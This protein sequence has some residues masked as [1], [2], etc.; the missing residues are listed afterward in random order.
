MKLNEMDLET[1]D[2]W[3][4]ELCQLVNGSWHFGQ[5]WFLFA[6]GLCRLHS[7][8]RGSCLLHASYP[9]KL[10]SSSHLLPEPQISPF[11]CCVHA[12]SWPIFSL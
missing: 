9:R 10:K 12:L 1:Q 4:V 6:Q 7:D 8:D 5:A 3:D 2:F 11:C